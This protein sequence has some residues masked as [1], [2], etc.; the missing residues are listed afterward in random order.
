MKKIRNYRI[1]QQMTTDTFTTADGSKAEVTY[2]SE[3]HSAYE[4]Q[5]PACESW[6]PVVGIMGALY[7]T[8]REGLCADCCE[9]PNL[10]KH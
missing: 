1:E 9:E 8:A 2:A 6:F 5:C 3:E 10:A 7:A 4:Q